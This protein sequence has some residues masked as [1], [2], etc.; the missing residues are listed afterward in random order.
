MI[1]DKFEN[2]SQYAG[3][4]SGVDMLLEKMGQ[5]D[6][7]SYQ[8]VREELDGTRVYMVG[9]AYDTKDPRQAQMEAHRKYIDVMYMLRGSETIYVKPVNELRQITKEYDPQK[10]VLLAELEEDVTAVRL[11]E[12]SFVVLFPQDA[13]APACHCDGEQSVVKIIGKA[14]VEENNG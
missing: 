9:K 10:D 6:I 14:L 11:E 3:L 1:L 4:N 7:T 12:G 2:A 5:V 8:P 13:H